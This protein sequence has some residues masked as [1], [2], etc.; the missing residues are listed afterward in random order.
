MSDPFYK[1][2]EWRALRAAALERDRHTCVVPGC[3]RRATHVD[4]VKSRRQGGA[5]ALH[6]LRSLCATHDAQVKEGPDGKRK[7][8]GKLTVRGCRPDGTPCDPNHWW[9]R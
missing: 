8:D 3:G 5:D 7:S 2:P 4:H 6:N 9:R 1:G